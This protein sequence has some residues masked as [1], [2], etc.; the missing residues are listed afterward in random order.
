[1]F[2]MLYFKSDNGYSSGDYHQDDIPLS[3]NF[4]MILDCYKQLLDDLMEERG[5]WT[6]KS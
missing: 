5:Y 4:E 1:M 3:F 6:L 2:G